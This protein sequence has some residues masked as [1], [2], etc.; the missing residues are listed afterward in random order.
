MM[1]Y[2]LWFLI[3]LSSAVPSPLPSAAPEIAPPDPAAILLRERFAAG[4][5]P[6]LELGG[7][8]YPGAPELACFYQ[9]RSFLPAW[10]SDRGPLPVADEFLAALGGAADEGLAPEDYRFAELRDLAESVRRL[11]SAT[12]R[13]ALDLAFSDAFF[14]FAADLANGRLNPE[15]PKR[16]QAVDSDC[17]TNP[18]GNAPGAILESAL[19]TQRVRT[20]L[21]RFEPTENSYRQL[22]Q[23]LLRYRDLARRGDPAPIAAAGSSLQLGN[24]GER[25]IQLRQRLYS[26]AQ[27]AGAELPLASSTP[28]FFDE[29]LA[30]AVR[31]FQ[32]R[33]GFAEDGVVGAAT[34]AELNRSAADHVR[35]I[36]AN[37]ERW[38]WLP[39]DLGARYVR[40][41][42]PAFRLDAVEGDRSVLTL[43]VIVGK[44][45]TSTPTLSSAMKTIQLNPSWYVPKK[46]LD[47]EILPKAAKDPTFLG[48][49][50]YV[51]LS[52]DRLRQKP[53][54][55]NALGRFKFVFPSRY[56][57]YLHDTPSRTLF[58]REFRALS[59]G[60]VRVENPFDLAV[61]ALR[62]D[63]QWTPEAIRARLDTGKEK[64]VKLP[65][66]LPVHI[67]YWTAWTGDDGV[68]R[69][70]RDVYKQDAELIHRLEG[71]K[72]RG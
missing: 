39:S 8:V 43:R 30:Q 49:L 34:L 7:Q 45:D 64:Q 31:Q 65:E 41:N 47:G 55:S 52:E 59:H 35:Q 58:S 1:R 5:T 32:A 2:Y 51:S 72:R 24:R 54:P 33:N 10:S 16:R 37:L 60:C 44:P 21:A 28:E 11:P 14:A 27:A 36:E 22:R 3:F 46:I 13:T 57:V 29:P 61:W 4:P 66:E 50:G 53:G 15:A 19:A 38:R 23:A 20:A 9:R 62:N 18:D 42:I 70:G 40:V 25:V 71:G 68:L 48:R 6:T 12:G 56:G 69:F 67:G 26:A 63:P 17:A